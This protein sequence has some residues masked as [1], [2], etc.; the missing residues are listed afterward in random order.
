MGKLFG[1]RIK[2]ALPLSRRKMR[3]NPA[4][5]QIICDGIAR[6]TS[7]S[8]GKGVAHYTSVDRPITD[9]VIYVQT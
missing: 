6:H 9:P 2:F 7:A 8:R 4:C 1:E 5:I 3:L